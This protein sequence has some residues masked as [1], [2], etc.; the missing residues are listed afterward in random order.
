MYFKKR[1]INFVIFLTDGLANDYKPDNNGKDQPFSGD[2]SGKRLQYAGEPGKEFCRG[3]GWCSIKEDNCNT[4]SNVSN[5]PTC[6][7]ANVIRAVKDIPGT[8]VIGV[9]V[10]D[11]KRN[12]NGPQ[13]LH[14]VSSCDA[15]TFDSQYPHACPNTFSADS[16][17]DVKTNIIPSVQKLW[18]EAQ[19]LQ[20]ICVACSPGTFAAHDGER[21]QPCPLDTFSSE[22]GAA[23]CTSCPQYHKTIGTGHSD[24]SECRSLCGVMKDDQVKRLCAGKSGKIIAEALCKGATCDD[25]GPDSLD[26]SI[27]CLPRAKCSS[28]RRYSVVFNC[29][30]CR[31]IFVSS[32]YFVGNKT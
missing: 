16:F 13:V 26:A 10:G 15:Y 27:C 20:G 30:C 23:E 21:C 11:K 31:L 29:C 3:R 8:K 9:F 7:S 4:K 18:E 32:F 25:S 5:A 22:P 19:K 1:Q 12:T 24:R 2:Y 28:V 17:D 14:N 6:R